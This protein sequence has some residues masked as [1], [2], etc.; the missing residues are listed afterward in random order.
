M[1]SDEKIIKGNVWIQGNSLVQEQLLILPKKDIITNVVTLIEDIWKDLTTEGTYKYN[2]KKTYFYW[3]YQETSHED[4]MVEI[5]SKFE[6][7]RPKEGLFKEPYDPESVTGEYAKHWVGI[8]KNAQENYENKIAIQKKEVTF[9]GSSYVGLD[10]NV[11]K[12]NDIQVKNND[13]G[14]ITNLLGEIF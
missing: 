3:E 7:P 4:D 5:T 2:Q 8:L 13:I 9:K 14:D 10:G 1:M 6:C 12:V 11:V